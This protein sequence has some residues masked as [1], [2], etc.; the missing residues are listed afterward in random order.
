M[1]IILHTKLMYNLK[2]ANQFDV[3]G[4]ENIFAVLN[5]KTK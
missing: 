1:N 4:V 3:V 5:L 2:W